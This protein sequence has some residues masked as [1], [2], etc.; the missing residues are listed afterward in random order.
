[1]KL[2]LIL[3]VAWLLG[4]CTSAPPDP[5]QDF[6][7]TTWTSAAAGYSMEVPDVYAADV[8]DDGRAVFFRWGGTVPVKVYLTDLESAKDRGLWAG[9]EPTGDTTLAGVPATRYDYTHCDGPFC[10][11][12]ASFVVEREARWL[13]LEFRSEGELNSVNQRILSSFTLLPA[14]NTD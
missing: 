2:L 13:T 1:M 7:W 3:T 4:T 6:E 8:E 5:P 11:R 12:I 9:E 10:S 14:G